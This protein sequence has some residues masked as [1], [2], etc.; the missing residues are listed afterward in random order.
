MFQIYIDMP[1]VQI[2]M[3]YIIIFLRHYPTLWYIGSIFIICT[4]DV[5]TLRLF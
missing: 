2:Y 4:L 1:Y 3:I 5:E